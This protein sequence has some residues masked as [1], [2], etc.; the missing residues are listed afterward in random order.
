MH[1]RECDLY[2]GAASVVAVGDGCLDWSIIGKHMGKPEQWSGHVM[3]SMVFAKLFCNSSHD[4]GSLGA[5]DATHF[6][7]EQ[8]ANEARFW[9]VCCGNPAKAFIEH[10]KPT[11]STWPEIS[12]WWRAVP[13]GRR[14]W[15]IMSRH[16]VLGLE[17]EHGRQ[18]GF[19]ARALGP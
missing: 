11:Q 6:P 16:V 7:P 18:K 10:A 2:S 8:N 5:S 12:V 9:L 19:G 4:R 1:D 13:R 3:E 14:V 17:G 15:F